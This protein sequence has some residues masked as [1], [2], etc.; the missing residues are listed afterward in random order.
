MPVP[1]ALSNFILQA[2]KRARG[3]PSDGVLAHFAR[4]DADRLLDLVDEDLAVADLAG[5]G[6]LANGLD[7]LLENV[8]GDDGL[9]LELGQEVHDVF[10]TAV[11][12]GVTLLAAKAFTS[13]TVRP[14][15]PTSA[16]ASRTSSSLNG[17]MMAT[18][19]FMTHAPA[20][21]PGIKRQM[22]GS[23]SNADPLASARTVFLKTKKPNC[24]KTVR[25]SSA[26]DPI[27]GFSLGLSLGCDLGFNL[28][29]FSLRSSRLADAV[30]VHGHILHADAEMHVVVGAVPDVLPW[31]A[32]R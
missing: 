29:L 21:G 6:G 4:T 14:F 25:L 30:F 20:Q 32:R 7:G 16:S 24:P 11:E 22:L 23:L 2:S 28:F 19:S 27:S 9:D 17:L 8:V 13:V 12:L 31:R 18:I 5:V 3:M 26:D 1:S 15:T 10:G